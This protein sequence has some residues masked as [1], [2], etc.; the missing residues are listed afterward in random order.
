MSKQVGSQVQVIG[1]DELIAALTKIGR[2]IPE[3]TGAALFQVGE[4]IM[5]LAKEKY[6]PVDL[7][8]LR[9]SGFVRYD[10]RFKEITVKLG[11]GGVSAPYALIQHENMNYRHTTG[12][13]KYLERPVME[14]ADSIGKDVAENVKL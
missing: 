9:A 4:E 6:V 2:E 14:R 12:G 5:A 11:F 3:K 10:N 8:A 13:P 7:G 1:G